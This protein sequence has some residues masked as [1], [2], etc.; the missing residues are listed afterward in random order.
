MDGENQV[1]LKEGEVKLIASK[2]SEGKW[3]ALEP[4]TDETLWFNKAHETGDYEF[5]VVTNANTIYKATL[6]WT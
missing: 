5:I 1:S 3:V 4:N 6:A 2:G